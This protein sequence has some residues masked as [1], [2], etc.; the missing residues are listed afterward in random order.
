MAHKNS[1]KLI[2]QLQQN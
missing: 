2:H 1:P